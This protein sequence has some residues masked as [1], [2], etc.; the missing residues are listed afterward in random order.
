MCLD[1]VGLEVVPEIAKLLLR[2]IKRHARRSAHG[3]GPDYYLS[4]R[5]HLQQSVQLEEHQVQ[6][7]EVCLE[8]VAVAVVEHDLHQ[9]SKRLLFRYFLS[10][11]NVG[12]RED[13][14]PGAARRRQ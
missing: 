2:T 3:A 7:L 5:A 14:S 11:R 9:Q 8:H 4:L 13:G 1:G 12:E 10:V 6:F